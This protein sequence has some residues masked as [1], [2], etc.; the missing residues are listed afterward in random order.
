MNIFRPLL[1][2]MKYPKHYNLAY[3]DAFAQTF[4]SLLLQLSQHAF[5]SWSTFLEQKSIKLALFDFLMLVFA[6]CRTLKLHARAP[7]GTVVMKTNASRHSKKTLFEK[8]H[9][10]TKTHTQ[11]S[12]VH[13]RQFLLIFQIF[14]CDIKYFFSSFSSDKN[15]LNLLKLLISFLS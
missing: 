1:L 11:T 14:E 13:L 5:K 7:T 12:L 9:R 8:S 15:L 2:L 4:A 3:K 6:N 10:L